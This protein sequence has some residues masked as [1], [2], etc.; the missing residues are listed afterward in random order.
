MHADLDLR[1]SIFSASEGGGDLL[2][3]AIFISRSKVPGK[4]LATVWPLW[5]A[6]LSNNT[7]VYSGLR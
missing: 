1:L 4:Y 3:H 7:V 2:Q 6:L 5:N